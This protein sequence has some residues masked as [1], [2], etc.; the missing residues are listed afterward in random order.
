MVLK[1]SK[2]QKFFLD[3]IK[4][5]FFEE[6]VRDAESKLTGALSIPHRLEK[7]FQSS[8]HGLASIV[9]GVVAMAALSYFAPFLLPPVGFVLGGAGAVGLVLKSRGLNRI[10]DGVKQAFMTDLA[11]GHLIDRQMATAPH[12]SFETALG[13]ELKD[14]FKAAG[15]REVLSSFRMGVQ[16]LKREDKQQRIEAKKKKENAL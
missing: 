2:T 14:V 15:R 13:R 5:N 11:S 8:G 9:G 12:N 10:M 16:V 7:W 6:Y 3:R 4:N 1:L